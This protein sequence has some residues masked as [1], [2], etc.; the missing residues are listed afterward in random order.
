MRARVF[1]NHRIRKRFIDID[2]ASLQSLLDVG[3]IILVSML[4]VFFPYYYYFP[5][6]LNKI[7]HKIG[8]PPTKSISYLF[9]Q[10]NLNAFGFLV[11]AKSNVFN[12]LTQTASEVKIL[13][14]D[15]NKF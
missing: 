7:T 10:L 6:N 14:F 1:D 2:L 3:T 13:N 15:W 11:A 12:I 8:K 9:A 4:R 5:H